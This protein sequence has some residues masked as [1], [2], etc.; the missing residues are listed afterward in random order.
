MKHPLRF[1]AA[2]VALALG[3]GALL[4]VSFFFRGTPKRAPASASC[5]GPSSSSA[6]PRTSRLRTALEKRSVYLWADAWTCA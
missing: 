6:V 4:G 1:L 3:A 5:G 2:A